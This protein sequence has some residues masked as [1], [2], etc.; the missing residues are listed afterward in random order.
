MKTKAGS[1]YTSSFPSYICVEFSIN[2]WPAAPFQGSSRPWMQRPIAIGGVSGA[3]STLVLRLLQEAS[4]GNQFEPV[5]EQCLE[6]LPALDSTGEIPWVIFCAG[7]I[8]GL[9]FGPFLDL[10][11]LV[12]SRWRRF[13]WRRLFAGQDCSVRGH[14]KV[15]G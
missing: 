9:C 4:R 7:F 11:W 14:Y 3:F 5:V 15:L 1:T 10:C 13:V 2:E 12:R 6:S 8:T